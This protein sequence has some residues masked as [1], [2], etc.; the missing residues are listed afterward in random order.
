VARDRSPGPAI[1]TNQPPAQVLAYRN[2]FVNTV[3]LTSEFRVECADYNSPMPWYAGL[4]DSDKVPPIESEE[5]AL[6]RDSEFQKLAVGNGAVG[7]AGIK[8][9]QDILP[10]GPQ[11]LD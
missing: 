1:Y 10:E 6:L 7:V 8:R 9:G 11:F 2:R 4:V 3:G 5:Y